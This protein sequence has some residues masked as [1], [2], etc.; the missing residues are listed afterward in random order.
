[1]AHAG[2]AAPPYTEGEISGQHTDN[3]LEQHRD[4]I[5]RRL[6]DRLGGFGDSVT[7]PWLSGILAGWVSLARDVGFV[8]WE[9]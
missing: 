1:V 3:P 5:R 9:R 6:A 2:F 4:D 7:A 8:R